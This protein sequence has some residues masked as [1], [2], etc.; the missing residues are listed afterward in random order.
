MSATVSAAIGMHAHR[1]EI[2]ATNGKQVVWVHPDTGAG[3]IAAHRC[4][5]CGNIE[6]KKF[7]VEPGR[8]PQ[9]ANGQPIQINNNALLGYIVLAICVALVFYGAFLYVK[10]IRYKK[11]VL[12]AE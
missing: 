4:P 11:E 7:L 10:K 3:D 1:C 2:C 6:W 8:L 5:Q 9:V 12:L